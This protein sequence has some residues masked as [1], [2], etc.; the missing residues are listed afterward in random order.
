MLKNNYQGAKRRKECYGLKPPMA[1][2]PFQIFQQIQVV[3]L[4]VV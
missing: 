2:D 3:I 1:E 4:L